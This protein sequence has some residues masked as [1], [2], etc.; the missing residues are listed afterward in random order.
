MNQLIVSDSPHIRKKRVG[1]TKYIM[2]EV[3]IAL[4]PAYVMACVFFGWRAAVITAIC[5]A[6]CTVTEFVYLLA[7]KKK[8]KEIVAA[9]DFSS[10]V[11]GLILALTMPPQVP[12]YVPF[13]ASIFAIAAVKM[14]FGGTGKNIANPAAAGRVFAFIAFP[15]LMIAGWLVPTLTAVREPALISGATPLTSF[16]TVGQSSVSNLDLFL[17]TGVMG[18]IGET[19]KL[20]LLV[21]FA[22]LVIR[23]I[24]DW[25][26]PTIYIAVTGLTHVALARFNFAVFLPSILGGSLMFGAIFMATDY[27]TSPVSD[28]ARYYYYVVFGVLTAVLRNATHIEVISFCILL[29]NVAVPLFNKYIR[30]KPFGAPFK[31]AVIYKKVKAKIAAKKAAREG[32]AA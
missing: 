20:A 8:L 4:V 2:L 26:W 23:K 5:L 7:A 10:V 19:C 27:V 9:F 3:C 22:Y 11:T 14:V 25:R 29:M 12:W 13:L 30:P 24:V 15:S 16:L 32:E 17:G 1:K 6:T 31:A 28:R 21:G 18:S